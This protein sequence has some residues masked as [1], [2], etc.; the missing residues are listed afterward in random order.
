VAGNGSA[1]TSSK[2]TK[3]KT[4]PLAFGP[5]LD[6]LLARD[7]DSCD[8]LAWYIVKITLSAEGVKQAC[9][10]GLTNDCRAQLHRFITILSEVDERLGLAGGLRKLAEHAMEYAKNPAKQKKI[11]F[12]MLLK[13]FVRQVLLVVAFLGRCP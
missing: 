12:N 13:T 4:S 7:A 1:P 9:A 2:Q 11:D 10:N 3:R 8:R 6:R 5:I